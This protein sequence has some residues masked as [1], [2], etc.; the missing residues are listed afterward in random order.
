[1]GLEDLPGMERDHSERVE[2]TSDGVGGGDRRSLQGHGPEELL[3]APSG[4]IEPPA[5]ADGAAPTS[6]SRGRGQRLLGGLVFGALTLGSAA[7]GGAV[8][9]PGPWYRSLRKSRA[10]PPAGVFGPVWTG[11]YTCIAYSGYRVWARPAS[12]ARTR[13]LRLWALQ[14]GLNASWSPLFFGS[15][16]PRASAVVVT[17]MIPTIGA[18]VAT[19]RKVDRTAAALMLPYLAWSAF[20]AYLNATIVRKNWR[21]LSA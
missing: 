19:A 7:L 8:S 5:V 20:A 10:N 17:A 16:R 3:E 15:H 12:P 1:M 18:Y 9:K 13:A 4:A 6:P 14:M 11:L 21:R 2:G